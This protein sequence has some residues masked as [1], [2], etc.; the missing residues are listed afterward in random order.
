MKINKR[1]KKS[2]RRNKNYFKTRV[3]ARSETTKQSPEYNG[4]ATS[5]LNVGT[6]NDK[7]TQNRTIEQ[8]NNF[9]LYLLLLLLPTQFGKHFFFPFSYLN[10]IRVDYLAPTIYLTDI[11][12]FLLI[13]LNIKKI[14][15]LFLNKKLL[16]IVG[17][18]IIN[19]IFSLSPIISIYKSIK[20]LE[21]FFIGII[22]YQSS[23][24]LFYVMICFLFGAMFE[25]L[26]SIFQLGLGHSIQ[27]I[28][29]FF[30]ERP[31]S[32]SLP[33]I[34]K[35]SLLG[36]E[37][38]RPYATFSHPNSMAGF[39]LLLYTF[40][41]SI[42]NNV[43]LNLLFILYSLLFIFS[44]LI[45]ISFS[46]VVIITYLL[47]NTYFL[48][49][50][51]KKPCRL[52]FFA[53]MFV[54]IIVGSVFMMAQSDPLTIQKR[55][56]L[57][58]NSLSIIFQ[59]PIFGVGIGSYLV[60]QQSYS[61]HYLYFFNQPVH[62]I[63]LLLTA[64][65]GIPI[66]IYF[67]ILLIYFLK[68]NHKSYIIILISAIFLTGFFDHYWLTLQQNILLLGVVGGLLYSRFSVISRRN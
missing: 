25:T 20:I 66:T 29:Y 56:E 43:K 60:A 37:F 15:V 36:H 68:K 39:Y 59:R 61:S 31:L 42:K 30:G 40:F 54:L 52:C 33:G 46:K 28:F 17:L 19:I 62:N 2:Q 48:I 65:L 27:G 50:N 34:A 44:C 10:G 32:L 26:I 22:I 58:K 38:L 49:L 1:K 4:I 47:L 11:L 64:E 13:V 53:R 5:R 18:F 57:I 8:L 12:A 6:R 14:V 16:I 3:I 24:N 9:L 23:I 45:M 21:I 41:L 35:A 63:F 67:S 55:I 51:S 7:F